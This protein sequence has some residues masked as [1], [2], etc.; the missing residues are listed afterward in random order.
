[1]AKDEIPQSVQEG[2]RHLIE[3]AI[4]RVMKIRKRV[5]HSNLIA[6]VAKQLSNR[7]QPS[8]QAIK[9]RIESLIEREYMEREKEERRVYQYI[10]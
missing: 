3:A 9:K 5:Q 6:E 4:V 7:F 10:A 1:M 8:P 2:R